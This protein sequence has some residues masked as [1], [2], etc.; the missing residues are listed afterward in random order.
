[1]DRD[2]ISLA[3]ELCSEAGRVKSGSESVDE[4]GRSPENLQCRVSA[5]A[6]PGGAV[7]QAEAVPL[8]VEIPNTETRRSVTLPRIDEAGESPEGPGRDGHKPLMR[9]RRPDDW[10][11][12]QGFSGQHTL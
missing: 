11:L 12:R 5:T 3:A 2:V 1:M 7:T 9:N 10:P 8:P 4:G 6:T